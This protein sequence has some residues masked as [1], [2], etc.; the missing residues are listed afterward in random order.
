MR[1]MP[2]SGYDDPSDPSDSGTFS[3]PAQAAPVIDEFDAVEVGEGWYQIEG[4]VT[5]SQPEGLTVTFAGVPAVDGKSAVTDSDGNFVLVVQVKTD[6]TDAGVISA[7][8]SN[9]NGTSNTALTN[10]NPT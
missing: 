9:A 2:D 4:H 6:G 7:V 5:A 3:P 8:T 1:A 10:M